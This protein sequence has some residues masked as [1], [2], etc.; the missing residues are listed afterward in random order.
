MIKKILMVITLDSIRQMA[1]NITQRVEQIESGVTEIHP[2]AVLNHIYNSKLIQIKSNTGKELSEDTKSNLLNIVKGNIYIRSELG[3]SNENTNLVKMAKN[4]KKSL[5][6]MVETIKNIL[7]DRKRDFY[8]G[9][10]ILY[11]LYDLTE[12]E[13][14]KKK[15]EVVLECNILVETTEDDRNLESLLQNSSDIM[16]QLVYFTDFINFLSKVSKKSTATHIYS[17]T[18]VI[19]YTKPQINFDGIS[20]LSMDE[21]YSKKKESSESAIIEQGLKLLY[22]KEKM[23]AKL[24]S[25]AHQKKESLAAFL[26]NNAEKYNISAEEAKILLSMINHSDKIIDIQNIYRTYI[27]VILELKKDL[28][29]LNIDK[30]NLLEGIIQN[31]ERIPNLIEEKK[32]SLEEKFLVEARKY[33][34]I[35]EKIEEN[36]KNGLEDYTLLR[37]VNTLKSTG[38]IFRNKIEDLDDILPFVKYL[39]HL[40]D[41]GNMTLLTQ[42]TKIY[43]NKK[44]ESVYNKSTNEKEI[45]LF[46]SPET[47]KEELERLYNNSEDEVIE[48]RSRASY[49][50]FYINGVLLAPKSL[51]YI[52]LAVVLFLLLMAGIYIWSKSKGGS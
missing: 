1:K 49:S 29:R 22:S 41:A 25:D 16:D 5:D 7:K 10:D 52:G 12:E 6:T 9:G 47:S 26:Q 45:E 40:I 15:G 17:T 27:D 2:I 24:L 36:K 3:T 28:C 44:L 20:V 33:A 48:W 50:G 21:L 37:K 42:N 34:Y 31:I 8:N 32:R 38:T 19:Q 43:L 13:N 14:K 30:T 18:E 4:D 39:K 11:H 51:Y 46:Y 35:T 23:I